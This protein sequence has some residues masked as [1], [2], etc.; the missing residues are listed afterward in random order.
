LSGPKPSR[1]ARGVAAERALLTEMGVLDDPYALGMLGRPMTV[2]HHVVRR[3]PQVVPTLLV[4]LA[5]LGARVLWHDERVRAALDAGVRQVAV[6]GAGFDSRP[7]RMRRDGVRFFEL[8]DGVTQ[9]LKRQR[10]DRLG[11][12]PTYVEADLRERTAAE[13]LAVGGLDP[14]QPTMYVLEGLTMYLTEEVVRRQLTA[15]AE[16]S[17]GGSRLTTDFYPPRATTAADRKRLGVQRLARTGS[18][19]TL[20]LGVTRDQAVALVGA[21]G[22]RVDEAVPAREAAR[23]LVPRG[24][25]LPVDAVSEAG[26]FLAAAREP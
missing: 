16:A 6:V 4:T 13:A 9:P 24:S 21:C 25:G 19:E 12:G 11:P 7:W 8:D 26:T 5:G 2:A 18:G 3:R 10:A 23:A 22:W 17:A 20:R 1:T 14:A 15:L